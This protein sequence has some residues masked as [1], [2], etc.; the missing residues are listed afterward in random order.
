MLPC[1]GGDRRRAGVRLT[2]VGQEN[3]IIP[4]GPY[5]LVTVDEGNAAITQDNGKQV[6]L[7]GG[8]THFLD[9]RNWKVSRCAAARASVEV[10]TRRGRNTV[11][12]VYDAENPNR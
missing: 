9:H 7:P 6:I 8:Q 3:H 12:K 1:L 4:L 11:R 2:H 5:T 10:L